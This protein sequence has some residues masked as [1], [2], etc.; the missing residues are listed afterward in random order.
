MFRCGR[1]RGAG[2]VPTSVVCR[3]SVDA[4]AAEVE[5][6]ELVTRQRPELGIGSTPYTQRADRLVAVLRWARLHNNGQY[7]LRWYGQPSDERPPRS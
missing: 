3:Y 5:V 1:S 6:W 7:L 2:N 4:L